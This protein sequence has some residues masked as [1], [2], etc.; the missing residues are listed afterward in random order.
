M[1]ET[2]TTATLYGIPL[3]LNSTPPQSVHGSLGHRSKATRIPSYKTIDYPASVPVDHAMKTCTNLLEKDS[4]PSCLSDPKFQAYTQ[5]KRTKPQK[6]FRNWVKSHFTSKRHNKNNGFNSS[7]VDKTSSSYDMAT[8][9]SQLSCYESFR[10]L[11]ID[12]S[13]RELE[14][15]LDYSA[16]KKASS[17]PPVS[18]PSNACDNDK[19]K[20]I[21][22]N[23][24]ISV[25]EKLTVE[26]L[27]QLTSP[28]LSQFTEDD[29][30]VLLDTHNYKN[31]MPFK[32]LVKSS[33]IQKILFI[34]QQLNRRK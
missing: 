6:G 24:P 1:K 5:Q 15:G 13:F 34:W 17:F 28:L 26:Q 16:L 21:E 11:A 8:Y 33:P 2:L 27:N 20:D 18:N 10:N 12:E 31:L 29:D 4:Y 30:S 22:D 32:V 19:N 9:G 14:N 23:L 25:P 7:K 3:S